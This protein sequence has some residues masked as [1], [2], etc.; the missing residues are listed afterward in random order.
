MNPV[1]G[2]ISPSAHTAFERQAPTDRNR[3]QEQMAGASQ[4][5]HKNMS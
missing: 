4:E 5:S 1:H 2:E 3:S